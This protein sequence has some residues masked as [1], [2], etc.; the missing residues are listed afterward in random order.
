MMIKPK[1]KNPLKK[2]KFSSNQRSMKNLLKRKLK[3][4]QNKLK[5][6]NTLKP[7]KAMKSPNMRNLLPK[8]KLKLK[9][10]TKKRMPK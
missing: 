9:V 8:S 5:K 6:N 1:L 2:N 7:K 4:S 3:L 10:S